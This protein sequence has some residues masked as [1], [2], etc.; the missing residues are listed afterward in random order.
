[1]VVLFAYYIDAISIRIMI[2]STILITQDL[3]IMACLFRGTEIR[4]SRARHLVTAG[5]GL[6]AGIMLP[7]VIGAALQSAKIVDI[8]D[9]SPMQTLLYLSAFVSLILISMGYVLMIKEQADRQT[10]LIA[11]KD[12]LT[13]SWNRLKVEEIAQREMAR[14]KRHGHPVSLIMLDIDHFKSINDRFGHAVGDSVLQFVCRIMEACIR[15]TDLLGRWGGEEF[16]ILLPDSGYAEAALIAQRIKYE[17]ERGERPDGI[18][19]TAS[20]GFATCQSLD[21]WDEWLKRADMALY[22]AKTRGR[23]RI[24]SELLE[25][26][27]NDGLEAQGRHVKMSWKTR[28]Q[29]GHAGIDNQ[30]QALFAAST[31]LLTLLQDSPRPGLVAAHALSFIRMVEAHM[32]D[33]DAL[34]EQCHYPEVAQHRD[35]HRQL[36]ARAY[37]LLEAYKNGQIR[38]RELFHFV[39]YEITA[40]HMLIE[41]RKFFALLGQGDEGTAI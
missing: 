39:A 1:V 2:G 20:L 13:G 21:S 25:P 17:I 37:H 41:D 34:L 12:R 27:A 36:I 6:N 5:L 11:T 29:S 8:A 24:E 15:P 26:I 16:V 32:H 33:E 10:R 28:F 40:Q 38:E 7:R 3:M 19:V 23:N 18:K 9:N 4:E 35:T 22:L 14:L 31:R 30:H